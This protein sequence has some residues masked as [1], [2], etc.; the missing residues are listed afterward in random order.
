LRIGLLNNLGAG[1]NDAQVTRLL[2]FL[3][4]H[5]DVV[6]V[7]TTAAHAVPEALGEL[8]R[9]E[10]D[11]L[12]VNGGDGT[13][14]FALTEILENQAFEGRIPLI[15]PL[16][17]GR[18]NMSALDLGAKSDPVRGFAELIEAVETNRLEERISP[19]HVIGVRH[20]ADRRMNYGMFFG[21]GMIS[22]AVAVEQKV[23]EKGLGRKIQGVASST[24]VTAGILGRMAVG[25]NTGILTPDKVQVLID[26]EYMPRS[27]YFLMISTSLH[28]LFSRMRPFWGEGDG[29]V[30]FTS[31]ASDADRIPRSL[32]G[33]LRGRPASFVTEESGYTS[34]NAKRVGLKMDCGFTID[35]ELYPGEPDQTVELSADH[36]VRFV[37]A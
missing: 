29:G 16:C 21:C 32:P 18:T 12:V 6:H 9:Q 33:I 2:G 34:R 30:R 17:G 11:L 25:D 31:I 23:F 35:G 7:E 27:E 4:R 22:R 19:R 15:A 14:Q 1:R 13:I 8:A 20:G 28:R 10:V 26:G 5:P 37:R 36:T 3:R 24:L